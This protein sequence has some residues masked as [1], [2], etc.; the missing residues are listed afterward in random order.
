M[1]K[2]IV[3]WDLIPLYWSLPDA[4]RVSVGLNTLEMVKAD[5][6]A[7]LIT[8]WGINTDASGGYCICDCSQTELYQ[9]LLKYRPYISF[10]TTPLISL[11]QHYQTLKAVADRLK[12]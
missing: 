5:I 3:K 4:E 8:D 12:Q 11:D 10:T 7:G 9:A 6:A 2:W 1:A